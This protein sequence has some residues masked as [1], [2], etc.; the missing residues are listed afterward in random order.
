MARETLKIRSG[1]DVLQFFDGNANRLSAEFGG[2][3]A[4]AYD[5]VARD[6]NSME[7]GWSRNVLGETAQAARN[8]RL[9]EIVDQGMRA[10]IE[11]LSDEKRRDVATIAV[12]LAQAAG[13]ID[14]QVNRQVRMIDPDNAYRYRG[15]GG[16]TVME[17]AARLL[18]ESGV[19]A[20]ERIKERVYRVADSPYLDVGTVVADVQA[21][22]A[23]R[24]FKESGLKVG[25]LVKEVIPAAA[26]GL[27]AGIHVGDE[28][29]EAEEAKKKESDGR[30]ERQRKDKYGDVSWTVVRERLNTG[31]IEEDGAE[32][33]LTADEL[34]GL[35]ASRRLRVEEAIDMGELELAAAN[36]TDRIRTQA[37]RTN[38]ALHI[39]ESAAAM[40]R[41]ALADAEYKND[42]WLRGVAG[43]A[44]RATRFLAEADLAGSQLNTA[45]R[46][47]R[48]VHWDPDLP[49]EQLIDFETDQQRE[50]RTAR[51]QREHERDLVEQQRRGRRSE[52]AVEKVPVEVRPP[53]VF[54]R[55]F[56][57]I[58]GI[59]EDV[60][61]PPNIGDTKVYG[62]DVAG[63]LDEIY[64]TGNSSPEFQLRNFEHFINEQEGDNAA[65]RVNKT[66]EMRE[67]WREFVDGILPLMQF[68]LKFQDGKFESLGGSKDVAPLLGPGRK[69]CDINLVDIAKVWKKDVKAKRALGMW[70]AMDG[71]KVAG[72]SPEDQV[73]VDKYRGEFD[74]IL[75]TSPKS[76]NDLQA[77]VKGKIAEIA[78]DMAGHLECGEARTNLMMSLATILGVRPLIGEYRKIYT[79]P[80]PFRTLVAA[81]ENPLN[82]REVVLR[83]MIHKI[84]LGNETVSFGYVKG[85]LAAKGVDG[86]LDSLTKFSEGHDLYKYWG[87]M[88]MV[89]DVMKKAK[90][91]EEGEDGFED[92]TQRGEKRD[93]LYES[94][95]ALAEVPQINDFT[96]EKLKERPVY[97]GRGKKAKAGES[98]VQKEKR[99][100]RRAWDKLTNF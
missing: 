96:L 5:Q 34:A 11:G 84:K 35:R 4:D 19:S 18:I 27:A 43:D 58:H 60:Y 1:A 3:Y 90:L 48:G 16:V 45:E 31:R 40:E 73:F 59:P 99:G 17:N 92:S 61:P 22:E 6:P 46:Q 77:D 75:H 23:M 8:I 68:R 37:D 57:R 55:E 69:D 32:R 50:E 100:L 94:L 39:E 42:P 21:A 10:A 86:M 76:E 20:S 15:F 7:A 95:S 65:T 12:A 71:N 29:Q 56:L 41:E 52:W 47:K 79:E 25:E 30:S 2:A 93:E 78:K 53:S 74:R 24:K 70:M 54:D 83:P 89:M 62:V 88:A 36:L 66:V 98:F 91:M 9:N 97:P 72:L 49:W 64:R 44:V 13:E 82:T 85:E 80:G 51:E 67:H 28:M 38:Y 14:S 26:A 81:Q 87:G 33:D 63:L